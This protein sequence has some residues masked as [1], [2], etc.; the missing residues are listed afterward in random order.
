LNNLNGKVAVVT[1]GGSG[2]GRELS[3]CCA[4]RGMKLVLADVDAPGMAETERLVKEKHPGIETVCWPLDVSQLDQVEALA[5]FV[6]ERFGG[7]HLLF[8]NAG[9]GSAGPIWE[10]TAKDWQWVLGVNLLGVAWGIKAFVPRM[11]KQ[12]KGHIVNTAS[13][14]GWMNGPGAG[15]YNVSKC[16]VVAMSESLV[17][18][19]KDVG[20]NIGVSVVSPAFFPTPMLK[21]SQTLRPQ[22]ASEAPL[23]DIAQKRKEQTH[24]A[25]QNGKVSAAQIAEVTLRAVEENRFYVFPHPKIKALV[26]ARASAVQ[27]E[28]TA[29]DPMAAR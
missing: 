2:L 27:E 5:N 3:L 12:G 25:M 19:L 10:S 29:F 9:V 8:N 26:L 16:G 28:T 1:G 21:N 15:I 23:S 20:G 11:L 13:A 17:A 22:D 4:Q 14:A 6:Q 24:Y 18:D 7:T